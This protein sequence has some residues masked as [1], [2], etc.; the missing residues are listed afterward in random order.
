MVHLRF[1]CQLYE[2]QRSQGR[3]FLHEHPAQ[4]SSWHELCIRRIL[5][6]DGVER[7]TSD[8]CQYG[9]ETSE[10]TPSVSPLDGCRMF[11]RSFTC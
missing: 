7:I 8:Q 5:G 11:R 1:V 6:M 9:Q 2:V 10:G 4:A 3:Y